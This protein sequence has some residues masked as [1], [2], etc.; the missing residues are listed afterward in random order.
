MQKIANLAE[1]NGLQRTDISSGVLA[2]RPYY[3]SD[4]RKKAKYYTVQGQIVLRAKDFSKLGPIMEGSV[5]DGITDFRAPTYSLA[6]EQA[7]NQHTVSEAMRSAVG[8]AS[9]ALEPKGQ[10]VAVLRLANLDVKQLVSLAN[11]NVHPMNTYTPWRRL[12]R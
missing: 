12:S 4:K 5:E 6:D 10:K 9:A 7:A 2:V 1:K 3:D 8:G 11:M